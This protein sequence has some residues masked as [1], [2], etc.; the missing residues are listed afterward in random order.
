MFIVD[1]R[2]GCIAVRDTERMKLEG[3]GLSSEL[4]SVVKYWDGTPVTGTCP[5]CGHERYVGYSVPDHVYDL[6][7]QLCTDLNLGRV[8]PQQIRLDWDRHEERRP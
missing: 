6:A 5:A 2:G 1:R 3:N 4:P 7:R 8:L